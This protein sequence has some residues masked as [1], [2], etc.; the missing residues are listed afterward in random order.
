MRTPVLEGTTLARRV[1][2]QDFLLEVRLREAVLA[3]A[4]SFHPRLAWVGVPLKVVARA[5][6]PAVLR[7]L[8]RRRE[9]ANLED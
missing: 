7:W 3:V 8:D 6:G 5:A 4:L 1:Q 2:A 9:R